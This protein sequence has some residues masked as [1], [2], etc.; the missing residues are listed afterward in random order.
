MET[1]KNYI[2]GINLNSDGS[3]SMGPCIEARQDEPESKP[4]YWNVSITFD[5]FDHF[6]FKGDEDEIIKNCKQAILDGCKDPS[7]I[8]GYVGYIDRD[9]DFTDEGEDDGGLIRWSNII[10]DQPVGQDKPMVAV[11]IFEALLDGEYFF[12]TK[13]KYN[14]G[15]PVVLTFKDSQ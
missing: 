9:F 11:E 10:T 2:V 6:C 8:A 3:I 15:R 4:D 5:M 7:Q 14:V 12:F 13:D 1:T